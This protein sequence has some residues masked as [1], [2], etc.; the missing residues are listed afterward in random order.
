MSSKDVP[1]EE[2]ELVGSLPV[3]PLAERVPQTIMSYHNT[4]FK[5]YIKLCRGALLKSPH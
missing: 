3:F 1:R 2:E 5:F 4:H